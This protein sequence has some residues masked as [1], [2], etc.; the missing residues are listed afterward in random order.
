MNPAPHPLRLTPHG[1]AGVARVA[2]DRGLSFLV[3]VEAPFHVHPVHHLHR[4]LGRSCQAVTDGAIHASLNMN[5][6]RKDDMARQLVHS[7]PRNDLL[8][9]DVLYH[10]EGLGSLTHRIGRVAGPAEVDIWHSGNPFPLRLAGA[11]SADQMGGFF[12]DRKRVG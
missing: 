6:V 3:T 11:E 1:S 12:G 5:P 10:L 2:I 4:S 7:F 8:R 9:L